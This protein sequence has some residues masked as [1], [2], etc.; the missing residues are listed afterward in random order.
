MSR[1]G[2]TDNGLN[3]KCEIGDHV[4]LW[5]LKS[6]SVSDSW[7]QFIAYTFSKSGC[8]YEIMGTY[9]TIVRKSQAIGL[10]VM[11]SVCD[12]GAVNS[13]AIRELISQ[14]RADVYRRGQE[15]RND[16]IKIGDDTVI[17]LFDPPH[18]LKAM[19]N[20]LLTKD[21]QFTIMVAYRGC[22][23]Y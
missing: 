14:S 11:P 6:V 23:L 5:M 12:Q 22:L 13:K 4:T 3:R 18:L 16:V 19:R 21:L 20:N 17:P 15:P 8:T 2:F 7:K 10:Q 9:K 1:K